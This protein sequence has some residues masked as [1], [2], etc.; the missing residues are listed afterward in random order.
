MNRTGAKV[1]TV[2]AAVLLLGAVACGGGDDKEASSSD[3]D[4][5]PATTVEKTATDDSTS[6]LADGL[7]DLNDLGVVS[8][9]CAQASLAYFS[10]S[11]QALGASFGGDQ[12]ALDEMQSS[13]DELEAEI[14]SEIEDDFTTYA[15]AL[16]QY[17]EAMRDLDISE[18]ATGGDDVQ[19]AAELMESSDVTEAQANI[20]QYFEDNCKS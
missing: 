1:A 2:L 11:M 19:Q 8:G 5:T 18:L 16:Q 3:L 10:L 17:G 9:D 20:E 13:I 7:D 4:A 15:D 6:D 12:A 14:P